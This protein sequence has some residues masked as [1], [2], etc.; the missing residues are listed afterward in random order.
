[1]LLVKFTLSGG[2]DDDNADT[3]DKTASIAVA[4]V[5]LVVALG[6]VSRKR[7]SEK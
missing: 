6:V 2:E 4:S 1:M 5:A 3:S 7:R